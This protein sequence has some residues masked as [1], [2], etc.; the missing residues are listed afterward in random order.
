MKIFLKSVCE[1]WLFYG[2]L[3]EGVRGIGKKCI[4]FWLV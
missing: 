4:V 2:Y 1:N 3:F